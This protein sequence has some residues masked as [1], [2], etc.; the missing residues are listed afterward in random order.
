MWTGACKEFGYCTIREDSLADVDTSPEAGALCQLAIIGISLTIDSHSMV[1]LDQ[2]PC[3]VCCRTGH[4]THCPSA[5]LPSQAAPVR[6]TM[7]IHDPKR[8]KSYASVA[9]MDAIDAR[10]QAATAPMLE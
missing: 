4:D 5:Q 3:L 1:W 6:P 2:I 10:I 8:G 7:Q 9:Q